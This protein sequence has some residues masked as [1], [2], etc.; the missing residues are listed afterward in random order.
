VGF[1]NAL[2]RLDPMAFDL[3]PLRT[4]DGRWRG[5]DLAAGTHAH[6]SLFFLPRGGA[7]PSHDHPGMTVL[8]RV[9]SGTVRVRAWDLVEDAPSGAGEGLA[10]RSLDVKLDARSSV[11][12]TRPRE[13]NIHRVDALEPSAFVDLLVPW[14]DDERPCSYFAVEP[15]GAGL[16][17]L[18]RIGREE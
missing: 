2:A 6:A 12:W 13:A 15:A 11:L 10:S 3:A 16:V 17:R 14:Y 18:R 1:A 7:I 8:T 4:L 5:D 9:I